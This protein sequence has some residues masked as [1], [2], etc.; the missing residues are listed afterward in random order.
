MKSLISRCA[1]F[2]LFCIIAVPFARADEP[3]K[4]NV[5]V[6][7]TGNEVD[8]SIRKVL[9]AKLVTAI[10]SGGE[11]AA[12]ERTADFLEALTKENDYQTSGEVRDSQIAEI[13]KKFG[14]KFVVV[15]DVSEVFDELFVASRL[16]NVV[17]GLVERAFDA[18]GPVDTMTQLIKLSQ[19]VASG[20]L[21]GSNNGRNAS[22]SFGG[23]NSNL[24]GHEYVDLGL[25]SGLK[26]ATCNVGASSPSDYGYYFAWGETNTKYDYSSSNCRTW[27]RTFGDIGGN[28]QYDAARANWGG[29]WRLPT[30]GECEE[31]VN[32]C[33]WAFITMGNHNGYKV[34]GPNGNYIC[35]R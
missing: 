24:N 30:R 31:L 10:T 27:E 13:G 20:L 29:S 22:S 35:N 28:V 16:I 21:K 17:T 5:A 15:A 11:Y 18:N 34:I 14:V 4:K 33:T 1:L 7:V 8:N 25:P 9:G 3:L 23:N 32:C 19:E 2:L 12:V 26:W 6:Y